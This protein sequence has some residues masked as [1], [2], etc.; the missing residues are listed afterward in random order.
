MIIDK[1]I[2]PV[3]AI[4]R[5]LKRLI[6]LGIDLGLCFFT[7]WLAF[8]LRLGEFVRLNGAGWPA[9]FISPLIAIPIFIRFGMYRAIFRHIGWEALAAIVNAT[10]IYGIAY[11]TIFTILG[12][13][14]VP[15]TVGI[16][17]PMLLLLGVGISRIVGRYWLTGRYREHLQRGSRQKVL[18]YGAGV[19]GRQ[20]ADAISQ[21]RDLI[22]VGFLDDDVTLQGSSLGGKPVMSPRRMG[23]IVSEFG[24]SEIL[25]ALPANARRRRNEVLNQIRKLGIAVRTLPALLDVARGTVT[26][27]DLRPLDIDDLLGRDPVAPDRM[28]LTRNITGKVVMVTGA[29]GSIG[30]ELCRQIIAA[31][32]STLLLVESNEFALYEIFH[33]LTAAG[34]DQSAGACQILPLLGSVCDEPRMRRILERWRPATFFHAAAYKHV[35]L[36][37]HNVVEGVRNNV[38]GTWTCA[39]LAGSFGVGHFVLVSTDKAVRPTNVM[40][41]SK[42]LAELG[43]QALA[44]T[45]PGTVFS[46]VRFG[47]VLGSSG[48]VVPLFRKQIAGGGPVTV[49]HPEITRYFMSIPEA[50]QLVIQASSMARG[51]EVFVLDMGEPIKVLDLAK[52]MIALSGLKLRTEDEPEGDMEIAFSG[53]RPGEKLF[54]ELLIGNDPVETAHPRVMMASEEYLSLLD[55]EAGLERIGA[56]LAK[57]DAGRVREILGELVSDYQPADDLV[58]YLLPESEAPTLRLISVTPPHDEAGL[59]HA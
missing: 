22:V 42:R 46:L 38:L 50:A 43:I 41:A 7:V 13:P 55:Y 20:L 51:G 4:P 47:N 14:G 37:E 40:G 33:E 6:V 24:I 56:A 18:I 36:V 58:D 3:L 29:G 35:P 8:Y 9:A 19:S 26:V 39:R 48:S 53:L 21:S 59:R 16:I 25:L 5:P 32:P 28:L 45:S 49:T 12:I 1:T 34:E 57:Q 27:T 52:R 10:V 11:A 15:R 44:S 54:E 23:E 17:Q 30:S 31:R 2:E